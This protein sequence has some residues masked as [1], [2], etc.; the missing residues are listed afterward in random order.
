MPACAI[1]NETRFFLIV[2]NFDDDGD[3]TTDVVAVPV[4]VVSSCKSAVS[5]PDSVILTIDGVDAEGTVD[6][7]IGVSNGVSDGGEDAV[8][9]EI[10]IGNGVIGP[11]A[12]SLSTLSLFNSGAIAMQTVDNNM[13][14]ERVQISVIHSISCLSNSQQ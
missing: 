11:A 14:G 9:D 3:G 1:D 10:A 4:V 6:G 8:V 2:C 13:V 12:T 5:A 7:G